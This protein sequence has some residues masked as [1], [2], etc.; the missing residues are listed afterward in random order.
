MEGWVK[1]HRCLIDSYVFANPT[2]LKI[3]MWILIRATNKKRFVP[4]TVGKGTVNVELL[5]GQ[6]IFGRFKAEEELNIDGSTIYKHIQ[7][8]KDSENINIE[9]NNHYTIITVCNWLTYQS[10]DEE[11]NHESNS[12]VTAKEQPSSSQVTTT[13]HKQES[14]EYKEYKEIY[15]YSQFYDSEIEQNKSAKDINSYTQCVS[16]MFGNNDLK[17][18]LSNWLKLENQISYEQYEK[19]LKKSREKNRKIS[20][21]LMSGFN[22]PKHLKGK[23]SVY[24]TL[25]NWL[26]LTKK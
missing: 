16:F 7:K 18:P 24:L 22:D 8:L 6:F 4:V 26:N 12:Q 11:D 10:K 13:E 5:P 1:L 3:W 9:S 20:D 2:T 21:M 25:N 17:K 14:K 23:S 19:L 15:T